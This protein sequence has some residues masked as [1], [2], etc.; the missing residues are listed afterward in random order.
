MTGRNAADQ[1]VGV[2]VVEESTSLD[3]IGVS[4]TVSTVDP[5]DVA[6]YEYGENGTPVFFTDGPYLDSDG[7]SWLDPVPVRPSVVQPIPPAGPLDYINTE[8]DGFTEFSHEFGV[9]ASDIILGLGC[10]YTGDP[11]V[12]AS[13]AGVPMTIRRID[14]AGGVLSLLAEAHNVPVGD[15]LLEVNATGGTLDQGA[16]RINEIFDL[17]DADATWSA[18]L[19]GGSTS[20]GQLK[21]TGAV[22]GQVKA[23]Y[24]H[25]CNSGSGWGEFWGSLGVLT[26]WRAQAAIESD[27]YPLTFEA[28]NPRW[29]T[30]GHEKWKIND[31]DQWYMDDVVSGNSAF[32]SKSYDFSPYEFQEIMVRIDCKIEGSASS[33]MVRGRY[34]NYIPQIR[35]DGDFDGIVYGIMTPPEPLIDFGAAMRGTALIRDIKVME[36]GGKILAIAFGHSDL[37]EENKTTIGRRG[38]GNYAISVI[39]VAKTE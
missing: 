4:E 25:E 2:W 31:D 32:Y 6:E 35:I 14:K 24:C 3:A 23:V 19:T 22:G 33:L 1:L 36:P 28:S 10:Y 39:E 13:I 15:A 20:T 30:S 5:V 16:L 17:V 18:G 27:P 21:I 9:A 26:V 34:G 7:V 11:E 38:T 37:A 8:E 12:S 29:G